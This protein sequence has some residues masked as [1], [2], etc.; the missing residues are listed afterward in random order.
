MDSSRKS[1]LRNK[2]GDIMTNVR[3]A[4]DIFKGMSPSRR[5]IILEKIRI[6]TEIK[7]KKKDDEER[8]LVSRISDQITEELRNK[9]NSKIETSKRIRIRSKKLL[10]PNK[11]TKSK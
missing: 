1:S 2:S 8:E 9:P 4:E 7:M 10:S 6:E 3:S 11:N 5:K